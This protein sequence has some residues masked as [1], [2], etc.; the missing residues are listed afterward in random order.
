[1]CECEIEL[2]AIDIY[3]RK[4]RVNVNWTC[5]GTDSHSGNTCML[6]VRSYVVWGIWYSS[7]YTSPD[8]RFVES[9]VCAKQIL[10]RGKAAIYISY[11]WILILK[12][13]SAR[14]C[15][16][17]YFLCLLYCRL[18]TTLTMYRM[19]CG[20][21][22]GFGFPVIY[23]MLHICFWICREYILYFFYTK[24]HSQEFI[25]YNV[26]VCLLS[27]RRRYELQHRDTASCGS[28]Q[29]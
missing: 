28:T 8:L 2:N 3:T 5:A 19:L 27:K 20:K 14:M 18:T 21:K 17:F 25:L 12:L 23:M 4:I 22:V 24:C 13:Y 15:F 16:F 6:Y 9:V 29:R 26:L 7:V 1:M 11:L 10:I